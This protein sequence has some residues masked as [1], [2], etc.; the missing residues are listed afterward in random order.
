MEELLDLDIL[1]PNKFNTSYI[2]LQSFLSHSET[3]SCPSLWLI[4]WYQDFPFPSVVLSSWLWHFKRNLGCFHHD[5]GNKCACNRASRSVSFL[6]TFL[7]LLCGVS[8]PHS[9]SEEENHIGGLDS[10]AA[11]A[12]L[13]FS[14]LVSSSHTRYSA[15]SLSPS[16]S[17]TQHAR[18]SFPPLAI[19]DKPFLN[20]CCA[21]AQ[22]SCLPPHTE[23][24][25]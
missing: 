8:L 11:V 10:T 21:V 4:F 12:S 7:H 14:I 24:P 5:Y 22:Y 13:C 9:H 23:S 6:C 20:G 15:V 2:D 17:A 25:P 19:F 18:A 1:S 16:P 3:N